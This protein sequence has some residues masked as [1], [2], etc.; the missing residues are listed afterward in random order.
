MRRGPGFS[1]DTLPTVQIFACSTSTNHGLPHFWAGS[2]SFHE[3]C[4][5]GSRVL[6][7]PALGKGM[8]LREKCLKFAEGKIAVGF[9]VVEALRGTGA[10]P[11]RRIEKVGLP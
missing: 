2:L 5:R 9:G 4:I 8:F 7:G 1:W 11:P 10:K 3:G 6:G